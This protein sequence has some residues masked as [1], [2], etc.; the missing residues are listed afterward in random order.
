MARS[1]RSSKSSKTPKTPTKSKAEP[2]EEEHP[3]ETRRKSLRSGSKAPSP[4]SSKAPSN[5]APK[6][7]VATRSTRKRLSVSNDDQEVPKVVSHQVEAGA[8]RRRTG[9]CTSPSPENPPKPIGSA[10]V[11]KRR[12]V[13][14]ESPSFIS[15][16][17]ASKRAKVTS[18]PPAE[19]TLVPSTTPKT[20]STT[21]MKRRHRQKSSSESEASQSDR[22]EDKKSTPSQSSI[23]S[24]QQ[25]RGAKRN[26]KTPVKCPSPVLETKKSI[27]SAKTKSTPLRNQTA[28]AKNEGVVVVNPDSENGSKE[29]E[30]SPVKREVAKLK[31]HEPIRPP[32]TK[33]EVETLQRKLLFSRLVH[34]DLSDLISFSDLLSNWPEAELS[35]PVTDSP[36]LQIIPASHRLWVSGVTNPL[37]VNGDS[38]DGP[39]P[40]DTKESVEL[41]VPKA[42]RARRNISPENNGSVSRELEKDTVSTVDMISEIEQHQRLLDTFCVASFTISPLRGDQE[43]DLEGEF[44]QIMEEIRAIIPDVFCI[45]QLPSASAATHLKSELDCHGYQCSGCSDTNGVS[46]SFIFFNR[47]VFTEVSTHRRAVQSMARNLVEQSAYPQ[48]WRDTLIESLTPITGAG[49]SSNQSQLLVSV[50]R[51]T[52]TGS[53]LLFACL[54]DRRKNENGDIFRSS[55]LP[56]TS[57]NSNISIPHVEGGC[58]SSC[59][60]TI[61]VSV[62]GRHSPKSFSPADAIGCEWCPRTLGSRPDL[63]AIDATGCMWALKDVWDEVLESVKSLVNGGLNGYSSVS[64][65]RWVLCANLEASPTSPVYQIIRDGY[66]SDESITR[67]RAMRN[68]HLKDHDFF[69]ATTLLDRLWHAFQHTC[70]DVCSCYKSVMGIEPP[71]TRFVATTPSTDGS[72][73]TAIT[74][75]VDP[76]RCVDYIFCSGSS[77][78]PRQVLVPPCRATLRSTNSNPS[79]AHHEVVFSLASKIGIVEMNPEYSSSTNP[80]AVSS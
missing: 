54:A 35:N 16:S 31:K 68:V 5:P 53:L 55:V 77:L 62:A 8:K 60:S 13:Q 2:S 29:K 66:P 72:N 64:T 78:Q 70:T 51:H 42:K 43:R 48:L 71:F 44:S 73:K 10:S 46:Q 52:S 12:V 40:L 19:S 36:A 57:K 39:V 79:A 30:K 9:V 17:P 67:L 61:T 20:R 45:K 24:T 11:R 33:K 6:T 74:A 23:G 3:T 37:T 38:F 75:S 80:V 76:R 22:E 25:K 4:S 50:L 7:T 65:M 26:R 28:K 69:D 1:S 58:V 47:D 15:P 59:T 56:D 21:V 32:M 63:A 14:L 18:P 49:D 27:A 34:D 41:E